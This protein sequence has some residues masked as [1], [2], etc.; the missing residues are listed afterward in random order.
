MN[1][2]L[3]Y[4]NYWYNYVMN[5]DP[6]KIKNVIK[7][8]YIISQEN[9]IH[10]DI[11]GSGNDAL[12]RNVIFSHGTSVYSRFY[13]EWLYN[14][15]KS[16]FRIIALDLP[17]HGLSGGKRGHF[18]MDILAQTMYDVHTWVI[19][20]W[21]EKNA[22]M[23][24]SL[25]G[26]NALYST[27]LDDARIKAVVC[28]NAALF[29]E[30][31]YKRIINM[32]FSLKILLPLVPIVAKIAPTSRFSVF[33]Y[34]DFK[35]LAKTEKLRKKI[36]LLIDDDLFTEKYTATGLYTQ[37]K[38]PFAKPIE[39]I[40]TPLLLITGEEDVLFS[41]EYMREIFS[42]LTCPKKELHILENTA[43]LIFQENIPEALERI[44]PWLKNIL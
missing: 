12:N 6:E 29:N 22:F 44:V 25:G 34:L 16:G 14:L 24:S 15:Y 39:N 31:A 40:R 37:L 2:N 30:K 1:I 28:H 9:K 10:L 19:E 7:E 41:E 11:Y 38:A 35:R 13:A 20:R 23:G 4:K 32:T 33:L 17:G 18:T 42:R 36:P 3:E 43:H 21:G 5:E 8:E 26:I 27:A